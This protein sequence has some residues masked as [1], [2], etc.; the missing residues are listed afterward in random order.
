LNGNK[1]IKIPDTMRLNPRLKI[2]DLGKNLIKDWRY[3]LL[4]S[5]DSALSLPH[6]SG[7]F[8][9]CFSGESDVEN[10]AQLPKLKSLTLAGN[11]LAAESDYRERVLPS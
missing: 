7:H 1:I 11:P 10:L 9:A 3:P 2:L 8:P 6:T 5:F 4:S